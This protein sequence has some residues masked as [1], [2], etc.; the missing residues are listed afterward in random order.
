MSN[1]DFILF[2]PQRIA[3]YNWQVRAFCPG[4]TIEYITGFRSEEA[5]QDWIASGQ[6][7]AWATAWGARH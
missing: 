5:A 6:S 2:K 3:D 1:T 7:Q 4:A